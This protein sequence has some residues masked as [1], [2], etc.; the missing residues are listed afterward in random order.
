MHTIGDLAQ[1]ERAFLTQ[2]FGLNYGA[3]LHEAAWGRDERPVVTERELKSLS[4]ETTFERDLHA[5]HDRAELGAILTR[6]CE[7][8][9]ADLKRK[10]LRGRTMGGEAALR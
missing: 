8:V 6:L 10:G 2:H 1:A 5:R 9:A 4:R 7:Q 3:W